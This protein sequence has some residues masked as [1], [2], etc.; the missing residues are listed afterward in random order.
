MNTVVYDHRIF[1]H[2]EFGGVSRYFCEIADRIQKRS[3]W[4]TRVIAP[5]YYNQY[6]AASQIATIGVFR[7]APHPRLRRLYALANEIATPP[8]MALNRATILHHTYYSPRPFT[9]S[10][11][12]V[13]TVY[14]MIH[15]L[16][17]QYFPPSDPTRQRKR[18]N[19]NSA[20]HVICISH[21][22]ACDLERILAVPPSKISVVHLGYSASFNDR[23]S[24][25]ETSSEPGLRPYFLYVGAR[26]GYKNFSRLLDAFHASSR[27]SSNFDLLAFGGGPFTREE[28]LKIQK[29][30]L[31]SDA[32]RH[33][34][35]ND[36]RLARYYASAHAFVYPSEYEGFGMPPLEAMSCGCP[37]A[38]S[39]GSS[40]SEVVG[41]AGEF[42][43]PS[44]IESMLLALERLA[45]DDSR[46]TELI[47]AGREQCSRFSWDR[48]ADETV[49]IYKAL[50]S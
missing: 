42:F 26:G 30:N 46:R 44:S 37:V 32:V 49:E 7:L 17:P 25:L 11:P 27:I 8:L 20:D 1:S 10:G 35:G 41:V 22:T 9:F 50:V 45:F 4:R 48:C 13:I 33:L 38:C 6:L 31:R 43:D 18:A 29:L 21:S 36:E 39:Y 28:L 12:T 34:S 19:V 2:Q 24:A 16:Y 47:I 3:D 40:I 15:E 14:D 5:F 23:R